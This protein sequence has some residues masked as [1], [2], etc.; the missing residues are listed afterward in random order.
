MV[1]EELAVVPGLIAGH[2][3]AVLELIPY[4]GLPCSA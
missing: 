3:L 4:G 2:E 1:G